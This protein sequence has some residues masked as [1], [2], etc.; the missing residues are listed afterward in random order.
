MS[1]IYKQR[2]NRI[3]VLVRAGRVTADFADFKP[4]FDFAF[5][6]PLEKRRV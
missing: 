5:F 4:Q 3:K 6:F 1:A 2:Q